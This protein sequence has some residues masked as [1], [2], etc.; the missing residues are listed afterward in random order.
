MAEDQNDLH[1]LAI[2]LSGEISLAAH[3]IKQCRGQWVQKAFSNEHSA[4]VILGGRALQL[5]HAPYP[6]E[7]MNHQLG[8]FSVVFIQKVDQDFE[9][10]TT[11]I[12]ES[13][14]RLTD[15]DTLTI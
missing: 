1:N 13:G 10:S 12:S 5:E 8:L 14:I 9:T 11:E 6:I 15:G 4:K 2:H 3:N 7:G